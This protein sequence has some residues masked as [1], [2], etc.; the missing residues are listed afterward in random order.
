MQLK[1]TI[2]TICWI[3][4]F[5]AISYLIG[6]LTTQNMEWYQ[7]L[8]KSPLTPPRIAFPIVWNLLYIMLASTACLLYDKRNQE[9][10]KKHLLYFA[11]Y[12]LMNWSWSFIFFAG[13][14]IA[15]GF[16]WIIISDFLL[17]FIITSLW[18]NKQRIESLFLVPTLLWGI[19]AAYL[20]GYI[21]LAN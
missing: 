14:K 11:A 8:V 13:Q 4:G 21:F 18:F 17:F 12:M 3:I 6:K 1:L 7:T 9:Y 5:L 16:Y 10:G 15:L 19:F 2:K 20:N